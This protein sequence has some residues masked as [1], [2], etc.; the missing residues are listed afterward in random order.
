MGRDVTTGDIHALAGAYALDALDDVERA[1]FARHAATCE[2]CAVEVAEFHETTGRMA[3]ASWS[4][5][6]PRLRR[7]VLDQVA[8][9]RQTVGSARP[10][11]VGHGGSA[12]SWRRRTIAAAAAAVLAA[13]GVV[14]TW[15]IAQDRLHDK[16]AQVVA[17]QREARRVSDVLTAPDA[18]LARAGQVSIV[19]SPSRN[20]AVAVLTDM[21]AT[22]PGKA[23]QLWMIQGKTRVTP[24]GLLR[25][26]QTGGTFVVDDVAGADT[27]G[28]SLEPA[29]GSKSPTDVRQTVPLK[30]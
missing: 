25:P 5:P 14:A 28:V 6:P 12:T 1:M 19:V 8:R 20:S 22:G 4:V 9:T 26:G 18:R 10:P 27:F 11:A 3:E 2:V 17:A 23:Y 30:V 16:D 13:G 24:V 29:G 15:S 21:P 7:S